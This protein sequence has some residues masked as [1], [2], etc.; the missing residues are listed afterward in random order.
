M[1]EMIKKSDL[2]RNSQGRKKPTVMEVIYHL[3]YK[4]LPRFPF[5]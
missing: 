3:K 1:L 4:L 5:V 2:G